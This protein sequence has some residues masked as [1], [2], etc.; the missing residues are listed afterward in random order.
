[1]RVFF[2]LLFAF[3]GLASC[4]GGGGTTSINTPPITPVTYTITASAG[5][6]GIVT[7]VGAT[8]VTQ[9]AS[10]SYTITP[11]NGYIIATLLVD[12]A[13][14]G[15]PASYTFTNVTAD[16][17]I[18]ATFSVAPAGNI[19]L[20]L[21]PART[22]GVAPLSVFFDASATTDSAVTARPFNDIE[23]TWSFGDPASGTW[24]NGAQPG[25][26]SKNSATGPVA[27]H[28]FET[29][30]SYTVS[31][32]VFDGTNSATTNT[33][34]T[35]TDPNTVFSG[36]NTICVSSSG[37]PVANSGGCP[38]GAAVFQQASFSTAV[39]TYAATGKRLLFKRGDS[40]TASASGVVDNDGP[41]TIGAYGTGA[42]PL[43]TSTGA[44]P[45]VL[46]S[47]GNAPTIKDWR[48]MDLEFNGSLGA[49]ITGI[50]AGNTMSQVTI[51]RVNVHGFTDGINFNYF[52]PPFCGSS[53]N[54]DQITIYD[55]NVHDIYNGGMGS[56]ISAQRFAF[57][58]NF[59][60]NAATTGGQHVIRLACIQKGVFSNSTLGRSGSGQHV[61]KLH[62]PMWGEVTLCSPSGNSYAEKI[63]I[64]DNKFIN[65]AGNPWTVSIEPQNEFRDE[66]LRNVIV[67]RNWFYSGSSSQQ[68]ALLISAVDSTVRNNIADMTG[69]VSHEF[70]RVFQRG[71]EPAPTNIRVYNNTI[72][73]ASG[74]D[75]Y[76][77]N[78]GSTATNVWVKNNL[79][80]A[81]LAGGPIMIT[82]TGA[83]GFVQANNLLSTGPASALFVSATPA[84]PA[85]FGLK[86]L[87][88]PAR[89]TGLSTVPVFSDLFRTSRP[90]NGVIDIGASE[91]P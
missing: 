35:V 80:S 41:G 89:D 71:V 27:A 51:A 90:Q 81:D 13:S 47:C 38:L 7:P 50:D 83:S 30:G 2:A 49:A 34:I 66:R 56:F 15:T 14:V 17:T 4:G 65:S 84:V 18:D 68:V 3:S 1:M 16:H 63:N 73:S 87:P 32:T 78:I 64:S 67:E 31:L 24:A 44:T 46:S 22:S 36:T 59:Y 74:G 8:T 26:S 60:D 53:T 29:P 20:S 75:F 9:G 39:N 23:Y 52:V 5:S 28:V 82:G 85:N 57:L 42:V 61:V 69:A 21:V 37:V 6:N 76:G 55:S 40:F 43:V 54:W 11:S 88:N 72:Y 33:T 70:L 45:L 12:G 91:G 86:A 77:V 79:G 25:V 19:V 62:G 10:Q 58:G 48:V